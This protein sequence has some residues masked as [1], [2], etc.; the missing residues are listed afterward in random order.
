MINYSYQFDVLSFQYACFTNCTRCYETF[1][2]TTNEADPLEGEYDTETGANR[3]CG[4]Q[5]IQDS[6][7]FSSK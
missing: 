7:E 4:L 6:G 2:S 3:A 5:I 1:G